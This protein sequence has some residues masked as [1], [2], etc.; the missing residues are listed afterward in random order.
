MNI[1]SEN[2]FCDFVAYGRELLK[3]QI[4]VFYMADELNEK[5]DK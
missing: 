2:Q 1:C 3:I 5:E 4:F